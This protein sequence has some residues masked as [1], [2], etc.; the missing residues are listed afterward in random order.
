MMEKFDDIKVGDEVYVSTE[1]GTYIKKVEKVTPMYFVVCGMFF[2]KKTGYKIPFK[3]ET[4]CEPIGDKY[5]ELKYEQSLR[6]RN[7]IEQSI[8]DIL[9]I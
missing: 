6:I 8:K 3:E 7:I 4:V 1:F 5:A 9:G 2:N